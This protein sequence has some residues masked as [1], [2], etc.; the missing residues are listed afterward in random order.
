M[1]HRPDARPMQSDPQKELEK[2][3]L[4]E[5]MEHIHEKLL[6]LSGKGGVGKSTVAANLAT[7]LAAA[8]YRVGLLDVDIHGPSIPRLLGLENRQPGVVDGMLEPVRF[9]ERLAVISIGF[10]LPDEQAPVIW[11][12]PRKFGAIRQFLKDVIWGELDYLVVD[13]PPGTGDEPLAVAE[14]VGKPAR[15][16]IV[17]T[18]QELAVSDVRRCV[19]FCRTLELEIAGIVENMSGLTCPHCKKQ[20]DLFKRGGGSQLA[21]E[22]G[23]PLLGTI[24][25]DPAVVQNG[26]CGRSLLDADPSGPAVQAFAT[27]VAALT[28]G[29]VKSPQAA[30]PAEKPEKTHHTIAIPLDNGRVSAHFGHCA[31]FELCEVDE[32]A[33]AVISRTVLES[34]PHEPGLLPRWLRDHGANVIIASGIGQRA[35]DLFAQ[36]GIR[37]IV[38]APPVA[39]EEAMAAYLTGTLQ[40]GTNVCDH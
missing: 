4:R 6:V 23:V 40:A 32:G 26:D 18:P 16:V 36:N 39:A 34:P 9:N 15:A 29:T 24:P 12:G 13:S 10:F 17:T 5:R 2:Q 38:G 25:I 19:S 27:M 22:A 28:H 20:I 31:A 30:G 33:K 8:G 1:T 7:S 14:M 37:V 35:Q 3:I 11:R 21:R